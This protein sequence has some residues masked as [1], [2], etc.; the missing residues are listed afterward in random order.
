MPTLPGLTTRCPAASRSNCMWVC[1]QTT[2]GAGEPGQR[3]CPALRRAVDQQHLIVAARRGVA[4][5]H[6]AEAG[7]V[8]GDGQR[9]PGRAGPG[10]AADQRRGGCAAATARPS[11]GHLAAV[12][13]GHQLPLAVAVH[14]D[15]PVAEPG[16]PV[17][18]RGRASG[19][20]R[21]RRAAPQR[22]RRP[23]PARPALLPGR[24]GCRGC[25]RA[26]RPSGS[27][28]RRRS[29]PASLACSQ[30]HCHS[31]AGAAAP[32]LVSVRPGRTQPT[33]GGRRRAR[34]RCSGRRRTPGRCGRAAG[35]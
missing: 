14:P 24:A 15:R 28:A 25:Q 11:A 16:Q 3:R 12:E 19:P 33:A 10:A 26:R 2:V 6:G 34:G 18:G 21:C 7:D 9:Q 8:E 35:H 20:A 23:R 27:A 29:R 1:P 17:Q 4:E 22:R 31:I 32:G 30:S 13:G 5:Q